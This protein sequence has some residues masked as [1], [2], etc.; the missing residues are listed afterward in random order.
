LGF[1]C[2]ARF[3]EQRTGPSVGDDCQLLQFLTVGVF[4]DNQ[5]D[6]QAKIR[7]PLQLKPSSH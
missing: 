7:W 4:V 3:R 5:H 1:G 2:E 6:S